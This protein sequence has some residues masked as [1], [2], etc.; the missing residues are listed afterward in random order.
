MILSKK[1]FDSKF[2]IY[3][4]KNFPEHAR[5]ILQARANANLVRFF[6][7][8]LSFLIPV[9]FFATIAL[10]IALFKSKIL[11]ET[12]KGRLSDVITASSI[13]NIIAGVFAIGFVI[14][15][16]CFIFGLL[17]G[18]HK[19]RELIFNSEQ[20]E[21]TM[22]HIWLVDQN[23]HQIDS[24]HQEYSNHQNQTHNNSHLNSLNHEPEA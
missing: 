7:P 3:L 14:A 15:F 22:K 24:I 16:I 23:N 17:Y 8:L 9:V 11:E 12:Q 4:K 5:R 19:A 1:I 10:L 20:L 21:A 13:Q 6:Y 2:E 18:L